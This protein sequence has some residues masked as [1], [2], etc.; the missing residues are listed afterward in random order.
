MTSPENQAIVAGVD[1]LNEAHRHNGGTHTRSSLRWSEAKEAHET[2]TYQDPP[3]ELFS[4]AIAALLESRKI[5]VN[6]EAFQ[7]VVSLAE[8]CK[9]SSRYST[10]HCLTFFLDLTVLIKE[11]RKAAIIQRRVTPG[12]SDVMLLLH[13]SGL[14]LSTLED[15]AEDE[16]KYPTILPEAWAGIELHML[17]N[18][19]QD[20]SSDF[21]ESKK[22]SIRKLLPSTYNRGFHIPSWM[23]PFP[24]EHTFRSTPYHPNRVTN[25][26]VLREMIVQEGQLAEQALRRL[27]G[28]IKVDDNAVLLDEHDEDNDYW[29]EDSKSGKSSRKSEM[30]STEKK[31]EQDSDQDIELLDTDNQTKSD[32]VNDVNSLSAKPTISLKL[33][34]SSSSASLTSRSPATGFTKETRLDIFGLKSTPPK[35]FDV[36]TYVRNNDKLREKRR[37]RETNL[38]KQNEKRRKMILWNKG[39]L[40]ND[41]QLLS[42]LES[43]EEDIAVNGTGPSPN[44]VEKE[45]NAALVQI[46]RSKNDIEGT[47]RSDIADTGIVNWER[48]RYN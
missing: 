35:P 43:D 39:L 36:V 40:R 48:Q 26:R 11:L 2:T 20:S 18:S 27:T 34:L 21:I 5:K 3:Q 14:H 17:Q 31:S 4:R 24:P 44:A 25:P 45:Y 16:K 46:S 38:T 9:F 23:P 15:E 19:D 28:V 10:T 6:R 12:I 42:Q 30:A 37:Q 22:T 7:F 32:S 1:L 41:I 8:E 29:E 33:S 47:H 13:F